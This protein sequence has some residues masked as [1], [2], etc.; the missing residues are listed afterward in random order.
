MRRASRVRISRTSLSAVEQARQFSRKRPKAAL[1]LLVLVDVG[2]PELRL[3]VE[4]MRRP[5]EDLLLLGDAG[6]DE[7]QRR[8]LEVVAEGAGLDRLDDFD[9]AATDG[10]ERLHPRPA[11]DEPGVVDRLPVRLVPPD[12]LLQVRR[13]LP[14][15]ALTLSALNASKLPPSS[16]RCQANPHP[17]C[18]DAAAGRGRSSIPRRGR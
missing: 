16:P 18:R 13:N 17:R 5:F 15:V 2:D 10:A 6:E 11:L 1:V 8:A 4:G 14:S 12:Q 3:P 9:D 7:L